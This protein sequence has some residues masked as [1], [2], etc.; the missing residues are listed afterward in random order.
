MILDSN[1]IIEKVGW[2]KILLWYY[3]FIDYKVCKRVSFEFRSF[4]RIDSE[5]VREEKG[6]F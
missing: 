1:Y 3:L 5:K 2:W 4:N 6:S